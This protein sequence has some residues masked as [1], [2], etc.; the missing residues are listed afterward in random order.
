MTILGIVCG[1]CTS[2]FLAEITMLLGVGFLG[3][4]AHRLSTRH[5]VSFLALVG[6]LL[7]GLCIGSFLGTYALNSLERQEK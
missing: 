1:I 2:I 5:L 4:L 6:S 7:V 3:N